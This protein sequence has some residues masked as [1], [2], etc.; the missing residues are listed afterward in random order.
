MQFADP[1]RFQQ[2]VR[3]REEYQ[4]LREME[5]REVEAELYRLPDGQ[6]R[7]W[8]V[9]LLQKALPSTAADRPLPTGEIQKDSRVVCVRPV[10]LRWSDAELR[11]RFEWY[12]SLVEASVERRIRGAVCGGSSSSRRSEPPQD[13]APVWSLGVLCFDDAKNAEEVMK[14]ENG[15]SLDGGAGTVTVEGGAMRRVL[16]WCEG[17]VISYLPTHGV[18]LMRS[19]QVDGDIHFEAPMDV[20]ATGMDLQGFRVDA[21]VEYGGDGAPQAREVRVKPDAMGAPAAGS[22]GE[23]RDKRRK[24]KKRQKSRSGGP[25]H[26]GHGATDVGRHDASVGRQRPLL[27]N[28]ALPIPQAGPVSDGKELPLCTFSRRATCCT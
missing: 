24:N 6:L 17:V 25:W 4:R 26:D 8:H 2:E 12:G 5:G 1:Q 14:H 28:T 15:G 13:G 20:R 19:A 27:Q 21:K 16:G 7:A 9:K 11:E 10:P 23:D 22:R 3:C 18:G